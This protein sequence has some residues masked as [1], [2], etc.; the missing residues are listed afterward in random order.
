MVTIG[1]DDT[2]KKAGHHRHDIKA[3]HVTIVEP[4]KTRSTFSTGLYENISHSG[5][6]S[7]E[8]VEMVMG[9]MAALTG[10]SRDDFFSFVDFWINDRAGDNIVML[11]ELGVESEKRL[12]CNAHVLLTI[13]EAI[14]SCFRTTETKTG[15]GK[16][17]S[18]DAGHVFT[19]PQNSIFY[20]GLIALSKLLSDSHCVESI[21]LYK[22]YKKFLE[23]LKQ[24]GND[25]ASDVLKDKFMGFRSNRFG[26]IPYLSSVVL[27]NDELLKL[28]FEN[29]VDENANKLVLACFSFLHSPWFLLCCRVCA[30]F[31]T[32]LVDDIL[33]ALGIDKFK[34]K[35]SPYRS[36]AGMKVL[37]TQKLE[38]LTKM[39]GSEPA[40]NPTA[41]NLLSKKCASMIHDNIRRQLDYM[42]FFSENIELPN[43]ET[44]LLQA[45]MTNDGC[46]SELAP[47]GETI[48]KVGS[49]VS[50]KSISDRHVIV[51][52]KLFENDKWKSL[53]LSEK[54]DY[55]RWSR[56]SKEAK[57]VKEKGKEYLE[58][59]KAAVN[60][61]LDMKA[62]KKKK[63]IKRSLELL[64]KL[65]KTGGPVTADD[66]D[67]M[68]SMST[69]DLLDQ[70]A[71]LRCT[72]VPNIK[73]KRNVGNKFEQFS[74]D[75]LKRQI[76]DVLKPSE[77]MDEDVDSLVVK[78][79]SNDAE[80]IEAAIETDVIG[81]IGI[82]KG[83]FDRQ[84][85]GV[86]VTNDKLQL[87]RKVKKGYYKLSDLPETRSEWILQ[88]TVPESDYEYVE[89]QGHILLKLNK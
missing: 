72:I 1:W 78:A 18:K 30:R 27:I 48:K 73:Q 2:V 57:L 50:L 42:S 37:F 76:S 35:S 23:E 16:L 56:N 82:W 11:D 17:I 43:Q 3:G 80:N 70:I 46:E 47:C 58:K 87:F 31:K 89:Y 14:D 51:R 60:L 26:R 66:I 5:E 8:T 53:T 86:Q 44:R 22:D 34:T 38:M 64:E 61:Q 59:V 9:N 85:V 10:I 74:D 71:Y 20:L 79:W 75:E 41:Y 15:K 62:E 52:N 36:W 67:R 33:S 40:S 65:K 49:T 45:P 84:C 39:S 7:T 63:K 24:E 69:K 12:F 19:S 25:K 29:N 21:S 32:I 4:D 77:D 81:R 6:D 68:K 55:M 83:S 54:R 13:D 88:E 28:F